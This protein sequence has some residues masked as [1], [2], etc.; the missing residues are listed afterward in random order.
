LTLQLGELGREDAHDVSAVEHG[1]ALG[2]AEQP[3]DVLGGGAATGTRLGLQ[4]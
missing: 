3:Q 4:G 2:E 1:D